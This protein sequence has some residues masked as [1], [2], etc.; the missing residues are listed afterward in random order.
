[1][2][3]RNPEERIQK[4][5]NKDE[6]DF[7]KW[8]EQDIITSYDS[9]KSEIEKKCLNPFTSLVKKD[10]VLFIKVED[11][12]FTDISK[13]SVSFKISHS[14]EVSVF[15]KNMH[16]PIE[17]FKWILESKEGKDLKCDKWSK[18]DTLISQ[19]S[20]YTDNSTGIRDRIII[21][22]E[23]L[24]EALILDTEINEEKITKIKFIL[25][26]LELCLASQKRYSPDL[27]IWAAT[28]SYS[29][30]GAYLSLRKTNV[31]TLPHHVYLRQFLAKIG[32]NN[33]GIN[34]AHKAFLKEK[35]KFLQ[36]E[37]KVVTLM[38]DEIYVN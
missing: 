28:L 12:S 27:L 29:F 31:L 17:N 24:K 37:D 10:H 25:E 20:G 2:Y 13:V 3:D 35:S 8:C 36:N 26:Q 23:F 22:K 18:F 14:L 1:M 4:V 7:G 15:Y 30:P 5:L 33:P 21:L 9:F 38:L 16:L 19:F 11:D 6:A 34:Y 32:P